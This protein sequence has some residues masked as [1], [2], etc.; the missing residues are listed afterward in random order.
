M[1][2]YLKKKYEY[3]HSC[4]RKN[5]GE[6][7]FSV[8]FYTDR[9]SKFLDAKLLCMPSNERKLSNAG[10]SRNLSGIVCRCLHMRVQALE[11]MQSVA[12]RLPRALD[13]YLISTPSSKKIS[14]K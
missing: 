10:M 13:Q 3:Q 1:S 2:P 5:Y 14:L 12:P 7:L 11:Q 9:N 4:C 8:I 6:Q